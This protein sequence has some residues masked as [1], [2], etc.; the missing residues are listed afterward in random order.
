MLLP[1][2]LR[3]SR[4]SL[5]LQPRQSRRS[6]RVPQ[7]R[8]RNP[9]PIPIRPPAIHFPWRSQKRRRRQ[10]HNRRLRSP[11]RQC[12]TV[13]LQI[14]ARHRPR[15][16]IQVENPDS[17]HRQKTIHFPKRN[18]KRRRRQT[19]I[20]QAKQ[21]REILRVPEFR[22]LVRLLLQK[23][24]T[25]RAMRICRSRRWEREISGRIL[26]WTPLRAIKVRM[27]ESTMT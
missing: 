12:K 1:Q 2:I 13:H 18:R 23:A 19:T 4:L 21:D 20:R 17:P 8:E 7:S 26:S 27:D 14:Q 22:S 9:R 10:M 5:H 3:S 24:G 6:R 11:P 16:Q 15:Q 25:V